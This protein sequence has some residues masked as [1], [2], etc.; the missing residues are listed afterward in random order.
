MIDDQRIYSH[1]DMLLKGEFTQRYTRHNPKFS[2]SYFYWYCLSNCIS[3]YSLCRTRS[4][5]DT[6]WPLNSL[7][8]LYNQRIRPFC[9]KF[10]DLTDSVIPFPGDLLLSF[11]SK[12]E[13]FGW[14]LLCLVKPWV[15][16]ILIGYQEVLYLASKKQSRRSRR[17][18]TAILSR[19][20][21]RLQRIRRRRGLRSRRRCCCHRGVGGLG[22]GL[23][24]SA[25]GRGD[26]L[27][28]V[29]GQSMVLFAAS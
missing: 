19:G 12:W 27:G 24:V 11:S 5:L 20:C 8:N 26:L 28:C 10:Q 16:Y 3:L 23:H 2:Y 17:W 9:C 1:F 7:F 22:C 29:K 21:W 14:W 13:N 4:N 18:G 15:N 6:V 25:F